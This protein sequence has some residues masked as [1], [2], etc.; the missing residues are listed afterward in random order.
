[1]S[2]GECI[3]VNLRLDVEA[4]DAGEIHQFVYLYFVV[5]VTDVADNR[6]VFHL[7][8]VLDGDDVAVTG[9]CHKDVSFFH[10]FFHRSDFKAF[11]SCLQGTDRVDFRYQYAGSV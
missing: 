3:F 10:G 11:H 4:F 9:G 1:M 5:E 8:H 6:L 2:V 7:L